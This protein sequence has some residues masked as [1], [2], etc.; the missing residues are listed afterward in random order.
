MVYI[1]YDLKRFMLVLSFNIEF[2]TVMSF[3]FYNKPAPKL[4]KRVIH[5]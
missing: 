1:F 5:C 4:G 3:Y 2:E